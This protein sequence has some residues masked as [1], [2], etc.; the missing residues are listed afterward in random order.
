VVTVLDKKS[1]TADNSFDGIWLQAQEL[2]YLSDM[3]LVKSQCPS[4]QLG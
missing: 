1:E 2:A 3:E 4:A